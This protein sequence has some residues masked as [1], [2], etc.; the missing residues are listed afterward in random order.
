MQIS[1]VTEPV[2]SNKKHI[3]RININMVVPSKVQRQNEAQ[4]CE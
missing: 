1:R 2:A 3:S 4:A